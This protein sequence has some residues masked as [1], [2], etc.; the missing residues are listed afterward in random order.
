MRCGVIACLDVARLK[1][2][3]HGAHLIIANNGHFQDR[4]ASP[5]PIQHVALAFGKFG[6]IR[7]RL[8][9]LG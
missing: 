7:T 4:A 2:R 9:A 3:F 1:Q 6:R 5:N 8:L